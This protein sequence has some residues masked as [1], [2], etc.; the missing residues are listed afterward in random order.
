[1]IDLQKHETISKIV[2]S[3]AGILIPVAI[4]VATQ[5]VNKAAE[6]RGAQEK[7][8]EQS[9][10][11]LDK[12]YDGTHTAPSVAD[13]R[14]A[15]FAAI[16]AY[17]VQYCRKA[18]LD[19]PSVVTS[20]IQQ[21]RLAARGTASE[22][23]LAQTSRE[24]S[25]ITKGDAPPVRPIL[26]VPAPDAGGPVL[27]LFMQIVDERQ[28]AA[29]AQLQQR[30]DG[31][32]VAGRRVAV[33][34]IERLAGGGDN[35]LRCLKVRDCALAG[36]LAQLINAQLVAPN[37]AVTD[38]SGRFDKAPGVAPGTYEL[39]FGQGDVRLR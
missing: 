1:M 13:E 7:C 17:T 11:L 9:I 38:L 27:R 22:A 34:G 33:Q 29:A 18:G 28:R 16:A 2:V 10:Q 14:R 20:T 35:S 30:L 5:M 3:Y 15:H 26:T 12:E 39:W 24:A 31:Q 21:E 6:Q 32:L 4:L 37:I 25:D 36:G 19:L 23:S 8:I